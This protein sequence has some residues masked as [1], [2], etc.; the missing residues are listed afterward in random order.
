MVK[1]GI[2]RDAEILVSKSVTSEIIGEFRFGDKWKTEKRFFMIWLILNASEISRLEQK[3]PRKKIFKV[4]FTALQYF[5]LDWFHQS[6]LLEA[7][8]TAFKKCPII[9]DQGTIILLRLR[10]TIA[11]V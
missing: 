11:T 7:T 4:P 6:F 10:I 9:D 1:S 3:C 5:Y 2:H 8:K